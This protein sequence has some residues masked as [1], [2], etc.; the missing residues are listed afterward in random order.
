MDLKICTLKSHSPTSYLVGVGV[1]IH[2]PL[3]TWGYI[4]FPPRKD[5]YKGEMQIANDTY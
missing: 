3:C 1:S 5:D 2:I 4:L